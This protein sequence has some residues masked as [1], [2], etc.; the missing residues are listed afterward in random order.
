MRRRF[1][2]QTKANLLSISQSSVLSKMQIPLI[3]LVLALL[4]GAFAQKD[5]R[6]VNGAPATVGDTVGVHYSGYIDKSSAAGEHGK[7]FDSSLKRGPFT[8]RLG[9]GQVIKGWD[10]G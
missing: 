3:I 1:L 4:S 8:F 2:R 9:S 5:S 7:M 10:Q 6:C